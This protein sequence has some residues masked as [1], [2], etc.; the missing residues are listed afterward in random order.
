MREQRV[1]RTGERR[2][3]SGLS[4][5]QF[6]S[7]SSTIAAMSMAGAGPA[8]LSGCGSGGGSS[9]GTLNF[10][11]FY[12]PGGDVPKQEQWFLDMVDSWNKEHETQV[13]LTYIPVSTY[14]N[15]TKLQTSFAAGSGP[16]IFLL[17]PGDFLRYYNG[18]I[19][20]DLTPYM[21]EEAKNDFSDEVMGT[22]MVDGKIYALP[23]EAEPLAMYYSVQAFE[24]AG[25]SEGDIPTTWDKLLDVAETLTKKERFGVLFETT[26]GYYQNFTW[27]PF[28]WMGGGNAVSKDGKA[29]FDSNATAEALKLWQDTVKKGVAPRRCLGDGGSD[30]PPNLGSG[31][32]AMQH[33]GIWAISDM[34]ANKPDF[35]YG[36][37]KLP[38]PQGGDYTTDIGGW[39]FV[40]NAQ[41]QNPEAAAEFCV[42]ALGSMKK[43]SVKR[44]AEWCTEAKSDIPP[45]KSAQ[46]LAAQ[47]GA[48]ES[49]PMRTFKEEVFPGGRSE[50]RFPADVYKPIS[51]AIQACQLDGKDPSRQAQRAG[52]RLS[53]YLSSYSGVPLR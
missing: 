52:E 18:G 15:G 37:F 16:D 19:L 21:S 53:A 44:V 20:T 17:S 47:K 24:G 41:G 30:V 33:A 40:A 42:W 12:A 10:W 2:D 39:A 27:Y 3:R 29:R 14:T 7:R 4:R 8:L 49:G 46:R 26:P 1:T 28:M 50:P 36:V 13:K 31:Y 48:F 6:L 32:C 45:R 34:A 38:L 43:G 11:Q 25:L 23:M 51:D 5:R 35:E 22:R 9:S